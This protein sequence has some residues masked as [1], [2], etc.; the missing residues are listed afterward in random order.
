MNGWAP[1]WPTVVVS[2]FSVF[3]VTFAKEAAVNLA[4]RLF[5]RKKDDSDDSE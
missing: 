3:L 4:K 5:G 1:H 2:I